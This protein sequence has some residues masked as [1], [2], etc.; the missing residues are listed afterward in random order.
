MSDRLRVTAFESELGWMAFAGVGAVLAELTF[1]HASPREAIAGLSCIGGEGEDGDDAWQRELVERLQ[2]YAAGDPE[3]FSDVAIDMDSV[4]PFQRRVVQACRAIPYGQ[5]RTY[6][7]LAAAVGVPQAARA[8]GNVMAANRTP[9]IVPC[10]RVITSSG[11]L[12]RYS[13][14]EGTRTKLRLIETEAQSRVP[15]LGSAR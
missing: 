2:A 1:G 5:T 4:T 9:L 7:E 10:H 15:A 12:G 14:G 11:V 8:V 13:A 3:D 6:G